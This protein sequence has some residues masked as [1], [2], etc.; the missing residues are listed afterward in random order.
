VLERTWDDIVAG[1]F[2]M[3]FSAP[4]LFG[5]RLGAFETDLRA[6]LRKASPSG[7]FSERQPSTEVFVWPRG[8]E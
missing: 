5:E 2:S 4:H 6:L 8:P 3:S 1:V 7:R